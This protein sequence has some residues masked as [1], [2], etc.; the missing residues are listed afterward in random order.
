MNDTLWKQVQRGYPQSSVVSP[1]IWNLLVNDM[2][3]ALTND[4]CKVCAYAEDILTLVEG[5]CRCRVG[6]KGSRSKSIVSSKGTRRGLIEQNDM[7]AIAGEHVAQLIAE[8]SALGSLEGRRS[9]TS[10]A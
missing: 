6:V 1:F 5:R 8:C 4:G 10:I 9:E 7:Y 2:L 3:I